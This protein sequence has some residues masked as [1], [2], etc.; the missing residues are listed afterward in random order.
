[1]SAVFDQLYSLANRIVNTEA[2]NH[3]SPYKEGWIKMEADKCSNEIIGILGNAAQ[4]EYVMVISDRFSDKYGNIGLKQIWAMVTY[5]KNYNFQSCSFTR[6]MQQIQKMSGEE[7]AIKTTKE[8]S[9]I[10][11][12]K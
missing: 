3:I 7:M 10:V 4:S 8:N 1:M 9:L 5:S 6:L 12:T 2:S 11:T